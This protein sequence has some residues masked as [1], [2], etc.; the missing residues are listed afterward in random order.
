MAAKHVHMTVEHA[1]MAAESALVATFRR[2][3]RF[4]NLNIRQILRLLFRFPGQSDAFFCQI[5]SF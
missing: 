3:D 1:H 5:R 2:Y 4:L